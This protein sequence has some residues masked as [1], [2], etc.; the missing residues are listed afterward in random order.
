MSDRN[1]LK[2]LDSQQDQ[3]KLYER[4]LKDLVRAYKSLDAE[5]NALQ[6]ALDSI[7]SE[8]SADTPQPE[9]SA[10]REK[11]DCRLKEAIA[12]LTKENSKKEAAFLSDKKILLTENA[13]LKEQLKKATENLALAENTVK[14]VQQNLQKVESDREKELLDH[15]KVV[16]EM[17]TRYAKEHH[18]L[19]ARTKEIASLSKKIGQKD[20]TISQLKSRETELI[21]E[22]AALSKDLQE[23]TAK[24][25]HMPSIQILKDEMANLKVDHERE[26]VDAVMKTRNTTQ[27]E[28]QSRASA[29]IIELEEKNLH[30]LTVI[31]RSEQARNDVYDAYIQSQSEKAALTE[32]LTTL[33]EAQDFNSTNDP[34]YRLKSAIVEIRE[35]QPDF[36]I[37]ALTGPHPDVARLQVELT[38]LRAEYEQCKSRLGAGCASNTQFLSSSAVPNE[39]RFRDVVEQFQIKIQN[40]TAA[41]AKDKALYEKASR[42][43]HGR[44]SELEQREEQRV[45]DMRRE[46]NNRISEMELEMQ[47]QRSR[48]VDVVTE[49]ERELEAA[50]SVLM[51]LRHEQMTA[52]ADPSQAGKCSLSRKMSSEYQRLSDRRCSTRSRRSV[53]ALSVNSMDAPSTFSPDVN[54][55]PISIAT[56]SRNIF[57]EEELLKKEREIQELRNVSQE[58]G[59]RLREM[60][61]AAI[62]KELEHHKM[63]ESMREEITE[64]KNKLVLL[65]TGGEMEYLRNIFIQFIHSN[66][67]SAKKNILRAMG[68]ALKLTPNEMKIIDSK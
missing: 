67:S 1:L 29:K 59:Y 44:I 54:G 66:N 45:I 43:L 13:S 24:A 40:L 51:S 27:L 26:L 15:G 16:A 8:A 47:K 36:N 3:L 55:F 20:E 60:E 4:K 6:T 14:T 7:V 61:Q 46:M 52:P 41:H 57:Y 64:L 48:T 63:I 53:D 19:E 18:L 25:H 34:V 39:E 65:S 17:Q 5:K 9:S 33:H 68:M 42:D 12:T 2:K 38:K 32:Q 58:H 49:K 28:E 11:S 50:R 23:V 31:A 56:E 37:F 62:V 30:L 22:I 10:Q 21:S 35:K